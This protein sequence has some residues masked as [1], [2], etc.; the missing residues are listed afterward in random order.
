MT[1]KLTVLTSAS[2]SQLGKSF[3]GP[4]MDEG[5]FAAGSDFHVSEV[6][7]DGLASLFDALG[8]LETRSDQTVIRGELVTL[9]AV[10]VR[11]IQ[12]NFR[13]VS[14]QWCMLDIDGL[15]AEE[16]SS[17]AQTLIRY[18]TEHLPQEFQGVD[19]W[20]Q[21]SS[22]MGI[23]PGIRVHL[24]YWL[25]RPCSDEEMKVWLRFCPVDMK[26]F[27]PIQ[28]HLTAAPQFKDGAVDP[29]PNRSGLFV[30]G[31]GKD[32]VTVPLDLAA[33]SKSHVASSRPRGRTKTNQLDPVEV[34]RDPA[35][36][37]AI[38]GRE[39]LLF[40]LS[41]EVTAA[42]TTTDHTP[43]VDELTEAL[44]QRFQEEADPTVCNG[45]KWAK[46]DAE[47]KAIARRRELDEGR[48]SFVAKAD[49]IMLLPSARE[50]QRPNLLSAKDA[51]T[52]LEQILDNFF[53]RLTKG[54]RPRET[55][56]ITM[57]T[58][59]TTVTITK[60]INY[61]S[62]RRG[63]LVEVYLPRH[64]LAD[65]WHEKLL[66]GSRPVNAEVVHVRPRTGGKFETETNAYQHPIL[67]ERA[68][69]VRDLEVK[70]Y[71]I[72][73]NA[74]L[75]KAASARC[76]FFDDCKYLGQFRRPQTPSANVIRLHVHS[77][78][79]LTRN[80]FERQQV[81]NLVIIDESFLSAALNDLP[82]VKAADITDQLRTYENQTLGFELVE[83]LKNNQG[84]FAYLEQKG[85]TISDFAPVSL[86]SLNTNPAFS[87]DA[88]SS[89][90]L[91][92]AKLYKSL[93][94]LLE[95]VREE[96]KDS[97]R[98]AFEQ[99]A[100]DSREDAVVV[101]QHRTTRVNRSTPVLY[102][103]ATAD[104]LVADAY[105]PDTVMHRVDV[106]QRAVVSQVFDRTGSN[107]FWNER[108][109]EEKTN[110]ESKVYDLA[111]N[112]LS[113]LV[114]VLNKWVE[115]GEAP[116]IVGHQGLADFLREHP[117]LDKRVHV[118]HFNSL[119]GT[120]EYKDCSVI[121]VTG[122]H[123]P[124]FEAI[125]RQARSVFGGSG[126]PLANEDTSKLPQKHIDYWLSDRSNQLPCAVPVSSFSD[127][128]TDAVLRQ[129]RDAETL[130][131]V[132]RLRLVHAE[133]Q[134]RVFLLSNLPVEMPVD[135]LIRFDELLPD[136]LELEL[137]RAGDLPLTSLGLR[138]MRPDLGYSEDAAKK[139]FQRSKASDPK[140]LLKQLPPLFRNSV[141]IAT[142]KA[143]DKRKTEH[144]HLFLPK[145]YSG[146]PHAAT[147]DPWT[148]EEV[149]RHLEKGWG[150]RSV[151]NLRLEFLYGA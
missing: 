146:D 2:G 72:Y 38:D 40:L 98:T 59:K 144:V 139:V 73:G 75:N 22:S 135:H 15:E 115:L 11:R 77:S 119:R 71:S 84:R 122:R 8:A 111:H 31:Q 149:L 45:R 108:M 79:F 148:E 123:Q 130:Q 138:K 26:L 97:T 101:C 105:F 60:L 132:A 49:K 121:F 103:D 3:S 64:D 54:V 120:D 88:V 7:V 99:L 29:F 52:R 96:W 145:G 110:L 6:I 133:Y 80:E 14:R 65:E 140:A 34:V 104:P 19:C 9:G 126:F 128:R 47:Q 5:R 85:L 82:V 150:E 32:T 58:G 68:D 30:A 131:V 46:A 43:T 86:Q 10:P 42:L 44:W 102:L 118:A 27:N 90:N 89:R 129:I 143:G 74:C 33:R 16:A 63:Q 62:G 61:L 25:Q 83:C 28:M 100:Y 1:D 112:D 93:T 127:P 21:F 113:A 69:Y 92:S 20:Y 81:P 12:Q 57:G 106:S 24:W 95:V 147:Y 117:H 134:K 37:L 76:K 17:D 142:F 51:R 39:K 141:Q 125:E 136:R 55:L 66:T 70:G 124:P 137:M 41:N 151:F 13:A 50:G 18:A 36:G 53:N 35:T 67:C 78:L 91:Q 56:R 114:N 109:D 23:K 87:P 107:N 94:K 4:S 116:L 48:F